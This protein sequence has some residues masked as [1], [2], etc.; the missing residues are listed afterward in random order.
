MIHLPLSFYHK[1][2][3][4]SKLSLTCLL[5]FILVYKKQKEGV[6]VW[7]ENSGAK[8]EKWKAG[9]Q[10]PS[11][12]S[13]DRRAH[14][15]PHLHGVTGYPQSHRRHL[16]NTLLPLHAASGLPCQCPAIKPAAF[17]AQEKNSRAELLQSE[18][19]RLMWENANK[20]LGLMPVSGSTD[21]DPWKRHLWLSVWEPCHV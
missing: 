15:M 1:A 5:R 13:G 7:T 10:P 11:L 6:G 20:V 18:R 17:R 9:P 3:G 2:N 16:K 19:P 4:G 12:P 14:D 21:R 8:E